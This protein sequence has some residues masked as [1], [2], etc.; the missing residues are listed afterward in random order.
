MRTL[1]LACMLSVVPG[2]VLAQTDDVRVVSAIEAFRATALGDTTRAVR[3]SGTNEGRVLHVDSV[4]IWADSATA[5]LTLRYREHVHR[6][7]FRL[8]RRDNIWHVISL[9]IDRILR[10]HQLRRE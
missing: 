4:V 10:L 1:V 9:Q 6:E 7:L 8:V 3:T 2:Q 5:Y